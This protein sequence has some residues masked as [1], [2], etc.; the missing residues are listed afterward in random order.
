[1]LALF[2]QAGAMSPK[3][4]VL[5]ANLRGQVQWHHGG[6]W[7]HLRQGKSLTFDGPN[8]KS[9]DKKK[10]EQDL[11]RMLSVPG[12]IAGVP[13]VGAQLMAEARAVVNCL[14]TM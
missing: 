9:T 1:M 12:G 3:Q 14:Q 4:I 11:R 7:A 8:R 13:A 5:R 6:W 2:G 10:A